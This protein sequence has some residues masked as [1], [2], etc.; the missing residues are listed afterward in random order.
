MNTFWQDLKSGYRMLAK[1][2]GFTVIA[3]LTL[4]LGIGACTA[5]FSVV[6]TILLKPLRYGNADKIVTIWRSAPQ[7]QIFGTYDL[8]WSARDFKLLTQ[9]SNKN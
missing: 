3:V 8:P 6:N 1:A 7:G 5:V 2:P 9:T 4:A